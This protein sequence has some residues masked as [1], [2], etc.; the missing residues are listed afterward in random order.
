M[1]AVAVI[2]GSF[3]RL[4][5]FVL[6]KPSVVNSPASDS[7]SWTITD[8]RSL[9][10]R[11]TDR[12]VWRARASGARRIRNTGNNIAR[13]TPASRTESPAA[14]HPGPKTAAG[15][16]YK[17]QL[18]FRPKAFRCGSLA[19]GPGHTVSCKQQLSSPPSAD[20]LER[21]FFCQRCG[22]VTEQE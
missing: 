11:F 20:S 21:S 16:S 1:T 7:V 4:L 19:G 14:A 10:I 12:C 15:A 17:Q 6:N 2:A 13:T 5:P 18:G 9:P 3:F 22:T 8:R